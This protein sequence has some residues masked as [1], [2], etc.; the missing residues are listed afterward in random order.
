[1]FR[2]TIEI[3]PSVVSRCRGVYALLT[4]GKGRRL[5][6]PRREEALCT[7]PRVGDE[8]GGV[9]SWPVRLAG[10]GHRAVASGNT[11][12]GG[13]PGAGRGAHGARPYGVPP[14]RLIVIKALTLGNKLLVRKYGT[15]GKKISVCA[16]KIASE[17]Q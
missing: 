15:F 2:T 10:A 16:F 14:L 1:M 4:L 17:P 9:I 7:A 12:R 11:A 13:P 6:A 3:A 8:V 5:P